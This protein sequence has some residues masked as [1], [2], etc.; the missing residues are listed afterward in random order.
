MQ[1]ISKPGAIAG[2]GRAI[3]ATALNSC[4]HQTAF[5]DVGAK[6]AVDAIVGAFVHVPA[7]VMIDTGAV[8]EDGTCFAGGN[9]E[10]IQIGA[11]ARIGAGAT[12]CRGVSIGEGAVVLPGAVVMRSVPANAVV[13]GNPATIVSYVD[14]DMVVATAPATSQ[15]PVE[16][17]GVGDVTVHHFP[18]IADI[19]G[20]L[21]VGEFDR[22]IPFVP[23]RYFMVFDVPSRETRGEHAHRECHQFLVC[24]R[25][26][27]AVVVDDGSKRSE[28]LLDSPAKGLHLPP[29]IWGVQYRYTSDALLLVF[30]SH[31]YD[32][33]DYIRSYTD[34]LAT[35]KQRGGKPAL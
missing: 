6:V 8:I 26:T 27:C 11:R 10:G 1:A 21:T 29:M 31:H 35:K 22:E 13:Q 4:V 28:I 30:A 17:V 23:H 5:F 24:V 18:V 16:R 33:S 3:D 2:E 14:V 34:F 15:A 7:G 32:A 12:L 25:G 9:G 19:R 20:S